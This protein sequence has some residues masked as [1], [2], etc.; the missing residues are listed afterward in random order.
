MQKSLSQSK[1]IKSTV[2]HFRNVHLKSIAFR[3]K[4]KHI[5]KVCILRD[6]QVF[7]SRCL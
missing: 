5:I 4:L 3:V 6:L 1:S 2:R 7:K